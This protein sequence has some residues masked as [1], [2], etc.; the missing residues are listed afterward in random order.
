MIDR[1]KRIVRWTA[2]A[3]LIA[4]APMGALLPAEAA[5]QAPVM[6]GVPTMGEA[7]PLTSDLVVAFVNSYPAVMAASETLAQQYNV[8]EGEEPMAAMAAFAM[9]TG[10]VAELNGIVGEYGF[11]DYGQWISVMFSV[12]FSY[13]ILEAPPEQQPMLLGMFGQTQENVDAVNANID[14]VREFADNL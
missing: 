7:Y 10:A 4:A 14:L 1:V 5:A 3:V 13:S 12:M 11:E 9:V 2:S 8:P 6:P